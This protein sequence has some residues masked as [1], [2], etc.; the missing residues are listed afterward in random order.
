MSLDIIHRPGFTSIL[1]H[2]FSESWVLSPSLSGSYLDG[3]RTLQ[4]SL[5]PSRKA[6][7]VLSCQLSKTNQSLIPPLKKKRNK[8]VWKW[9]SRLV[10]LILEALCSNIGL[11]D[12]NSERVFPKSFQK[13]NQDSAS[14]ATWCV[15]S[16]SFSVHHSSYSLTLCVVM[17]DRIMSLNAT[18]EEFSVFMQYLV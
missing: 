7:I 3:D 9:Y 17:Q 8:Q 4:D 14:T 18:F 1:E 2:K 15:P 10:I 11:E 5:H 12:A 16:K 13:K 6:R